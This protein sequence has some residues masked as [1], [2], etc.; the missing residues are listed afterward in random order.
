MYLFGRKC[1]SFTARFIGKESQFFLTPH[2]ITGTMRLRPCTLCPRMMRP[3]RVMHHHLDVAS[4]TE[5]DDTFL[6][7][8]YLFTASLIFRTF[9]LFFLNCSG[10]I[11]I[12][13]V[14]AGGLGSRSFF[15][16]W[17][18][19]HQ[20]YVLLRLRPFRLRL[21]LLRFRLQRLRLPNQSPC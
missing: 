7:F 15:T 10:T 8:S 14:G 3:Y 16:L 19:L 13:A 5:T 20:N 1:H 4:P 6:Y 17:L 18:Q 12:G 11:Q 21:L 2:W 9:P